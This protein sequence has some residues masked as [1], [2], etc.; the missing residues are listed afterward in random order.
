MSNLQQAKI[1]S[2]IQNIRVQRWFFVTTFLQNR[3]AFPQCLGFL[4]NISEETIQYNEGIS[5]VD[6]K[7]LEGHLVTAKILFLHLLDMIDMEII[8]CGIQFVK[9]RLYSS[10]QVQNGFEEVRSK[11]ITFA[12]LDFALL[13]GRIPEV[14]VCLE[15]RKKRIILPT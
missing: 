3:F 14:F 8:D 12:S 7:K 6:K 11:D 2:H 4:F 1:I 9:K 13:H 5:T 10:L 15:Q